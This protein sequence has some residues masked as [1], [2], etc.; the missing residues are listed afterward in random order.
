VC[1]LNSV[2]PTMTRGTCI[3]LDSLYQG[4]LL[5][6]N[7]AE[8]TSDSNY[9]CEFYFNAAKELSPTFT[10]TSSSSSYNGRCQIPQPWSTLLLFNTAAF[11]GSFYVSPDGR[12][13]VDSAVIWLLLNT[14]PEVKFLTPQILPK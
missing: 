2:I 9:R 14:S 8:R 5:C 1:K 4:M 13:H 12:L 11:F 6:V 7:I 10:C 3:T